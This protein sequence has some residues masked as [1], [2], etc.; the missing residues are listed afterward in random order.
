[1]P[2]SGVKQ[3]ALTYLDLTLFHRMMS[4]DKRSVQRAIGD[5]VDAGAICS[6][7]ETPSS[8]VL[9]SWQS[10][11]APARSLP[12][13]PHFFALR[14]ILE[15]IIRAMSENRWQQIERAYQAALKLGADQRA[16]F[17]SARPGCWPR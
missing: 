14:R 3:N 9:R 10:K 1:M 16:A 15:T 11:G 17:L 7:A 5:L 6:S 13:N 2:V 12:L 8:K 4:L